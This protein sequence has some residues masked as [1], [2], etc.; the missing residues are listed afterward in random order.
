[1]L[2]KWSILFPLSFSITIGK[3]HPQKRYGFCGFQE[4]IVCQ[5]GPLVMP[6]LSILQLVTCASWSGDDNSQSTSE[7]L[8]AVCF[9]LQLHLPV[10]CWYPSAS[11]LSLALGAQLASVFPGVPHS[12]TCSPQVA[13]VNGKSRS[14]QKNCGNAIKFRPRCPVL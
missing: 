7:V 4:R 11:G 8:L 5:V 10:L 1:M 6:T 13:V 2:L 12:Y 3:F 9:P 14:M